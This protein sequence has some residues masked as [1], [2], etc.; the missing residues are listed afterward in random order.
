MRLA[1]DFGKGTVV[2]THSRIRVWVACGHELSGI[3]A[4]IRTRSKL[5]LL[6][7]VSVMSP[8]VGSKSPANSHPQIE[9]STSASVGCRNICSTSQRRQ[10]NPCTLKA[11]VSGYRLARDITR[12]VGTEEDN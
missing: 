10:S 3:T 11:A 7:C 12:L 2:H 1:S 9:I 6:L 5:G 4:L 8:T